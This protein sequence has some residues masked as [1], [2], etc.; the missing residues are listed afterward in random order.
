[1]RRAAAA[2]AAVFSG[3]PFAKHRVMVRKPIA[4]TI[5]SRA[6]FLVSIAPWGISIGIFINSL[7]TKAP[8]LL[9]SHHYA[10][11]DEL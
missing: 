8:R 6:T 11:Q 4:I 7:A 5:L 3:Y 1:M 9:E 10:Q 2:P